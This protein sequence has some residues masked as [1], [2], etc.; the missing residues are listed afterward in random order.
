MPVVT[1]VVNKPPS[2]R[3]LRLS[4]GSGVASVYAG[5][6]RGTGCRKGGAARIDG[7]K[8]PKA[9][10]RLAWGSPASVWVQLSS[11]IR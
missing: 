11:G 4:I 1:G 10:I 9:L 7:G 6:T 5:R 2:V 8:S 3:Y